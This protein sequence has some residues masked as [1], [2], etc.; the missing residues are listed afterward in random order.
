LQN[1]IHFEGYLCNYYEIATTTKTKPIEYEK[2][3]FL[4]LF[5]HGFLLAQVSE[6]EQT[7]K[8]IYK[9]ALTNAKCYSWLDHLSNQIVSVYLDQLMLI[10]QYLH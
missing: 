9:S 1:I 4:V 2:T 10:K 6:E 5:L 3:V 7:I 8:G